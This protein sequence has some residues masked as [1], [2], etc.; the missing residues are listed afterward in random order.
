METLM[1]VST[2]AV[3]LLFVGG[4]FMTGIYFSTVSTERTIASVVA[5]EAFAKIRLYGFDTGGLGTAGFA[6]Y[7]P[8]STMPA[9]EFLYPSTSQVS[10]GRY[11]WAA[12]YRRMGGSRLAQF[13]VFICR[14]TG[15]GTKYWVRQTGPGAP[16]LDLSDRPVPVWVRIVQDAGTSNPA[17]VRIVDAVPADTVDESAFINDGASIVDNATGQIYRV[18]RRFADRPDTIQLDRPWTGGASGI[19]WAVPSAASGGRNP[20]IAVYQQVLEF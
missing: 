19:V 17:E 9:T 7:R 15:T 4:T 10:G 1:A 11:S 3:G 5:D 16:Q 8:A 20:L 13:T 6:P 12:V 2:L 18:L 14:E